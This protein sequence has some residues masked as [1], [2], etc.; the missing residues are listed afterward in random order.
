MTNVAV[1]TVYRRRNLELVKRLHNGS[2]VMSLL[3]QLEPGPPAIPNSLGTGPGGRT[4]LLNRLLRDVGSEARWVVFAD[5]DAVLPCGLAH[6]LET[7]ERG[8]YDVAQPARAWN[9]RSHFL[10]MRRPWAES[11]HVTFVEIGP[12]VAIGPRAQSLLLPLSED[13][14]MGWGADIDWSLNFADRLRFGVVD[15]CPM[16]HAGVVGEDYEQDVVEWQARQRALERAGVRNL[17]QLQNTKSTRFRWPLTTNALL[18]R[19]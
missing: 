2:S 9:S 12:I 15:Q 16:S 7:A 3:W 14:P 6:F 8:G 19:H 11:R 18:G 1:A 10:L 17:R 4:H 5:D 13:S